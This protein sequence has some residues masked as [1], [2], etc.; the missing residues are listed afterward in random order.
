MPQRLQT[1]TSR[2]PQKEEGMNQTRVTT[3]G[4]KFRSVLEKEE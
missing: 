2:S 1:P 3:G 4:V